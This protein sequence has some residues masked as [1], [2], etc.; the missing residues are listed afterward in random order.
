MRD[1]TP[2]ETRGNQTGIGDRLYGTMFTRRRRPGSSE[3]CLQ[4]IGL[5]AKTPEA[6]QAQTCAEGGN[7]SRTRLSAVGGAGKKLTVRGSCICMVVDTVGT[8]RFTNRNWTDSSWRFEMK[9]DGKRNAVSVDT[10]TVCLPFRPGEE[11]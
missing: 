6:R 2:R 3:I 1:N 5:Y 8:E 7:K 11:T 9:E 4:L 10:P